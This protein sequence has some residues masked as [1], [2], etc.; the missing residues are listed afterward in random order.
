MDG[1]ARVCRQ[2]PLHRHGADARLSGY[3]PHG[4]PAANPALFVW[5]EQI[6]AVDSGPPPLAYTSPDK[7]AR[8]ARIDGS[9]VLDL[10]PKFYL[11]NAA[12]TPP[13]CMGVATLRQG[14]AS[15]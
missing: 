1:L 5:G 2:E 11:F 6:V 9:Q 15:L 4:E 7:R 12:L 8:T 13:D 3:L 14:L 10:D